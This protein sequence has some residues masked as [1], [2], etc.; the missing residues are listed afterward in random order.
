M[1]LRRAPGGTG[2]ASEVRCTRFHRLLAHAIRVASSREL[3]G[4]ATAKSAARAVAHK[5]C[6]EFF[7][8]PI[9]RN[10]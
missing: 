8:Y 3:E 7:W 2:W 1:P 6:N 5:T 4:T 9:K 10:Y